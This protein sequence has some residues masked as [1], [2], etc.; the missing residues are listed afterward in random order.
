[1][2]DRNSN[3]DYG[4]DRDQ[5]EDRYPDRLDYAPGHARRPPW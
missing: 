3:D 1:M 4:R 2:T 5:Q